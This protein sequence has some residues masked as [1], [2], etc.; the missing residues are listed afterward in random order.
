MALL[1]QFG[2]NATCQGASIRAELKDLNQIEVAMRNDDPQNDVVENKVTPGVDVPQ[3][4][5]LDV[6][7]PEAP[8][9]LTEEEKQLIATARLWSIGSAMLLGLTL[10]E[11]FAFLF[12][13]YSGQDNPDKRS[14]IFEFTHNIATVSVLLAVPVFI[15]MIAGFLSP[16]TFNTCA[17][18]EQNAAFKRK[19]AI[20]AYELAKAFVQTPEIITTLTVAEEEDEREAA[21]LV[22]E[23]P[24]SAKKSWKCCLF[25]F[26]RKKPDAGS[27]GPKSN[28]TNELSDSESVTAP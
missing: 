14:L 23:V 8:R 7:E 20:E 12:L 26:M 9:P 13:F 1:I 15:G 19:Q 22:R 3:T 18:E 17:S 10:G 25:D 16:E 24:D 6:N 21:R 28:N 11:S 2:D 27:M 5:S 4:P